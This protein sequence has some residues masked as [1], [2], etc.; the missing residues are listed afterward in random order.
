MKRLIASA[1]LA[2][3]LFAAT[4]VDVRAQYAVHGDLVYTMEGDPIRDGIVL[5][6]NGRISAVGAAAST[7]VPEGYTTLRAAV[8]T[9]GLIDARTVVGLAGY[10]NQP[11][12]Q[13]QLEKSAPLQP[14]LRAVDAYNAQERL[15]EWVRGFGVTTMHTGHGPGAVVS[16]QT[17]IVKTR[18]D[19]L[20]EA[21]IDPE[22]MLAVTFGPDAYATGSKPPG[23]RAKQIALLRGDLIKAQD[24]RRRLSGPVD[25]RPERDL[26]M[27]VFGKVLRREMPLLITANRAQDIM[28]ALRIASEFEIDVVLDGAA[29]VYTVLERVKAAGVP[30]L[31]HA[32][33]SRAAGDSENM[34][35]ETAAKLRDAGIPFAIQSG[36]EGYVP[37]TRVVLF[38]AAIAAA[39]GLGTEGALAAVTIQP[40][41]ILGLDGRVGSIKPGKDADL[42]LFDGDPFEYTS[43]VVG[44]LIDGKVESTQS[45]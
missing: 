18:G 14:E 19:T 16:G 27:D 41:R 42:V 35:W 5:V 7:A 34:S 38:E 36:Y 4:P 30:V 39:H 32:T 8:V 2:S 10:L 33:M 21:V 9:P 13:D 20:D 28:T 11:H 6:E 22:T 29:E 1:G 25:Q 3:L 40:A 37:K 17:M 23:T 24:Y 31:L 15:V 26:R 44:V 43:H 45:R 12:E